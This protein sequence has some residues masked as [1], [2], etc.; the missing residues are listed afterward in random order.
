MRTR[1]LLILDR[2]ILTILLSKTFYVA[3]ATCQG[4]TSYCTLPADKAII[5]AFLE[6]FQTDE[7][8]KICFNPVKDSC[9]REDWA[10]VLGLKVGNII[11]SCI[12]NSY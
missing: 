7:E 9:D 3:E 6:K 1:K 5:N 11:I 10:P 8:N 4:N 2:K 12:I